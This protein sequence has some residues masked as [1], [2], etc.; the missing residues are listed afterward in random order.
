MLY[1]T[2]GAGPGS[3]AP[4]LSQY[5]A[6]G[7]AGVPHFWQRSSFVM[8]PLIRL[9]SGVDRLLTF[10]YDTSR[11]S[12]PNGGAVSVLSLNPHLPLVKGSIPFSDRA[13]IGLDTPFKMHGR[14]AT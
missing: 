10:S 1:G 4:Q 2:Y 6:P 5:F 13:S 11:T 7:D 14:T 3:G 12:Y 8:F 9:I